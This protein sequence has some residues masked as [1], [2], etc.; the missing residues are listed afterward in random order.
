MSLEERLIKLARDM[1]DDMLAEII[2]FAEYI[3]YKNSKEQRDV[4]DKFIKENELALRELA[5]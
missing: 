4:V 2:D 1:P 3:K 5:K